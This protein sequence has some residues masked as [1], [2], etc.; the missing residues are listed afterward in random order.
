M[1]HTYLL[2]A[3]L[4][5]SHSPP[6][7]NVPEVTTEKILMLTEQILKGTNLTGLLG[8]HKRRLEVKSPSVV[9]GQSPSRGPGGSPPE[10]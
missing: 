6:P 9:Q 1:K 8:G 5:S 7:L 10:A 2:I 3:A 4:P